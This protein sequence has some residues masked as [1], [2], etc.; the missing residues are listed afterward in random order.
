MLYVKHTYFMA[1]ELN[2][3]APG[4]TMDNGELLQEIQR[5]LNVQERRICANG[6]MSRIE[7]SLDL[8]A[9]AQQRPFTEKLYRV[10]DD[11]RAEKFEAHADEIERKL[12]QIVTGLEVIAGFVAD[13][14]LSNPA[15]RA[16]QDGSSKL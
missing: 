10:R 13:I 11:A 7:H 4:T 6:I 2:W 15:T 14:A 8:L 16:Q 3:P 12:G 9:R 5:L 1:T